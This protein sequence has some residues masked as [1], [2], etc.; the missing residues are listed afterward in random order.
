MTMKKFTV[1]LGVLALITVLTVVSVGAAFA[2]TTNPPAQ[3]TPTTPA[4]PE[5]GK[6][7]KGFGFGLRGGDTATF[8]A[9]AKALNLTPTQLFEQLHSGKTLSDIA[10][11]QGVDLAT[12]QAAV[13]ASRVQ[14]MKDK[15][16]AAVA[17]GTITQDQANWMLQGI[18]KGWAFGG[19]GFGLEFGG[20]GHGRGH[21][22]MMPF[23]NNN[24]TQQTP[25]T[26][27][28]GSSS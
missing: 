7:G 22:G 25:G 9:V 8:D 14:A 2:Q 1:V 18:E 20:R 19:R 16:A 23:G 26:S 13:N 15:I 6:L 4:Q 17:A 3:A 5:A 24:G 11:A 10:T 28:L 12:V 21:G 27:G